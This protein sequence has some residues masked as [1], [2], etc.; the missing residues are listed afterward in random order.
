MARIPSP[1]QNPQ[2]TRPPQNPYEPQGAWRFRSEW[3]IVPLC[4]LGMAYLLHHIRPVV[5]WD[6]VMN[7]LGVQHDCERYT[8][9]A[10][11]CLTCTL[12]V[13]V[14]R[15]LRKKRRPD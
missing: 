4:L 7:L 2:Q 15:I 11:L 12:L 3:L 6:E 14:V 13:A 1:I 5:T 10:I 8:M 9:L